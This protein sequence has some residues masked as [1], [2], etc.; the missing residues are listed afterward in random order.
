M[1]IFLSVL[2]IC[3][4]FSVFAQN[5]YDEVERD[6]ERFFRIGAKGGVNINKISGQSYSK[7]FNYNFQVGGFMQF[8]FSDHFG[9]QPEI[10]FVQGSSEFTD[11]AT[12][13]YDDLFRDGQQKKPN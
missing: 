3:L 8:N 1:K 10:N 4:C 11:D 9:I 5:E 13:V 2:G 7:G 6:P 12:S